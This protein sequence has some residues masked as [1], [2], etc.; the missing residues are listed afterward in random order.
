MK[1]NESGSLPELPSGRRGFALHY[2]DTYIVSNP[3]KKLRP[4]RPNLP[5]SQ[6]KNIP[7][8]RERSLPGVESTSQKW[9]FE[10]ID[11]IQ[12]KSVSS[13]VQIP[14]FSADY[15]IGPVLFHSSNWSTPYDVYDVFL[16]IV[17]LVFSTQIVQLFAWIYQ[18]SMNPLQILLHTQHVFLYR[19][20]IDRHM[21]KV[22]VSFFQVDVV[23]LSPFQFPQVLGLEIISSIK[24]ILL[25]ETL[26]LLTIIMA[27]CY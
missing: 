3:Q 19:V 20:Y 16:I 1:R 22:V 25:I 18:E 10:I 24:A 17:F 9:G 11:S 26:S 14:S 13:L 4:I 27:C 5:P 7:A 15:C 23:T 8:L 2:K 21:A 12:V 6:L